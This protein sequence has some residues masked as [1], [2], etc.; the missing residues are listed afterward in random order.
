MTRRLL[1]TGATGFVGTHLTRRFLDLGWDVSALVLPGPDAARLDA[2]IAPYEL[3]GTIQTVMGAVAAARPDVVVHLASLFIAEH[4]SEQV[5]P[6]IAANVMFGAQ[7]LEAMDAAGARV[8]VNTG[9]SWQ[10]Y[11]GAGYDPVCLYAATKQAFEDLAA[12]YVSA[13]GLSMQTLQLFDTYGPDDPR[14]KLFHG[15]ARAAREGR[16][17]QMS[18]GEQ[19]ID[20]VHVHDVVSAFV[21]AVDRALA[22]PESTAETWA[23]SAGERLSLRDVV[24]AWE[25]TTGMHVDVAWGGRPYRAREV[26]EPW[27]GPSLPGWTPVIMLD[28]GLG[29]TVGESASE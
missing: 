11:G 26:M 5:E 3:D 15:L 27:I 25:R 28:E 8:L 16:T 9:T 23:I 10:H 19:L 13:R 22:S 20:L 18:P 12:Y 2:R 4:T 7:L 17:L 24:A 14:P 6:L 29:D 1:V 21:I